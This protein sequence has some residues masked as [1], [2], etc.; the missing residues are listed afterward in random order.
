MGRAFLWYVKVVEILLAQLDTHLFFCKYNYPLSPSRFVTGYPASESNHG[1]RGCFCTV[2][3]SALGS[4][5]LELDI[6]HGWGGQRR[7]CCYRGYC[8]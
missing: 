4:P 8:G 5:Q 6:F 2:D 3:T 7:F 1:P